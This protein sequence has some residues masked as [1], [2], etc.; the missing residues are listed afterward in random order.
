MPKKSFK[1]LLIIFIFSLILPSA[2]SPQP[3]AAFDPD[4]PD[5]AAQGEMIRVEAGQFWDLGGQWG[6]FLLRMSIRRE[7]EGALGAAFHANPDAGTYF[8]IMEPAGFFLQRESEGQVEE[9][10]VSETGLQDLEWHPLQIEMRENEIR[11]VYLDEMVIEYIDPNPILEGGIS[12]ETLGDLAVDIQHLDVEALGEMAAADPAG[13]SPPT[14]HDEGESS[15]DNKGE[16]SPAPGPQSP[17]V[18]LQPAVPPEELAPQLDVSQLE[19]IRLGGPPGGTG[20]DIRYKFDDPNTW[21]VTDANSGV[22]ISYDNGLTWVESNQ[23][24]EGQS[25]LTN[26]AVGIFCLTVDPHDPNII[27]IGTINKG[28]IYRSTDGGKTWEAR[29]N[30]IEIEY[31]GLT[32]RGFTVDPRSSDIVYA[33]GETIDES[34]GGP[35]PWM[36]GI[37]GVVYKTTDAGENWVKI[38][39]GGMPSSLARYLWIDPRDPDTLYVSTGIFDRSAVGQG[40]SPDDPMGGLGILKSTDGGQT[41]RVLNEENGLNHLYVGSLY[42]HPDDPN[43]L[44]AAVGHQGGPEAVPYWENFS[45]S[46]KPHPM[47]VYR[48]EDGGE[49][50]TQTLITPELEEFSSVELCPSD[51]NIG[52]AGSRFSM[53]RT[54]DAGKTWE[55]TARPWSPPGILAGY[56]IDMQCDPRDEDRVFVNNYGG[57][58][59][60][61]EDGGKTWTTASVGYTGA[62]VFDIDIAAG[63]PSRVY[64]MTFSGLWRTD[65]AGQTWI[66]I[67]NAPDGYDAFRFI[68]ADPQNSDH[69]FSGQYGFLESDT[70]G[71]SY[72]VN[73]DISEIYD[74]EITFESTNGGIPTFV[75]APSDASRIYV[76]FSHE[77]CA[78]NHEPGCMS[79]YRYKGPGFM[80]SKDGGASWE[81]AVDGGLEGRDVRDVAVDPE[82]PDVV[83]VTT[84]IGIYKS[85]NAG[86]SWQEL[87]FPSQSVSAYAISIDPRA[88]SHLLVGIDRD[89]LYRS[90]NGGDTWQNSG[91]GMEP[92]GSVSS[93]VFDPVNDGIIYASD[94]LSGVYRSEDTGKTWTKINVGLQSRAIS[95]LA[96]SS[97]GNHVY[98]GSH[99]DGM[100]RLDLNGQPPQ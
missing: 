43:V 22:H 99:E 16:S 39:D 12:F 66:G 59:Y 37:G 97:N 8:L 17:S 34:L 93:I 74:D 2:C 81:I 21:Y 88:P 86:A 92:N 28:H 48:T 84:D 41:W 35:R 58:N 44:L 87:S 3:D 47:G 1:L 65:D 80:V 78:L 19:W 50:W 13:E 64:I 85:T 82:N 75:Y 4:N 45:A 55:L 7:G 95:E 23:G 30:G 91:A 94:I 57:G 56:P 68:A 71:N 18:V 52:Y 6:D 40:Q 79:E 70:A 33:M 63:Y 32:F 67:R 11:V 38:W 36:G 72:K 51:P 26:D 46:G 15:P 54:T 53:Y 76:G 69:V 90:E 10:A 29:E 31:D 25:G 14:E 60:L 62:Q 89:S 49:T 100:Y 5:G 98:A 20:Y 61:S 83:Y 73:W 42:M 24:L 9:L 27:W 77:L 96:I